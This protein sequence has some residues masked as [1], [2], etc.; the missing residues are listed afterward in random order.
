M[1]EM[2]VKYVWQ[3]RHEL[4]G[5]FVIIKSYSLTLWPRPRLDNAATCDAPWF[6]VIASIR[7]MM[8]GELR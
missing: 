1:L 6:S 3:L 5:L 4:V 8:G 2:A 7:G